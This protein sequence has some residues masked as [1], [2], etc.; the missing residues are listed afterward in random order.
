LILLCVVLTTLGCSSGGQLTD[1]GGTVAVDNEPVPSGTIHFQHKGDSKSAGAGATVTDGVFR[2]V[3]KAP[4]APGEYEVVLQAFRKTG[5]TFNDP[6]RGKVDETV[7]IS[8][9]D[10]PQIVQL[11]QDN[12]HS[13]KLNFSA[14]H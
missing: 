2:L 7:P 6:Q 3:S 5:K 12:E 13:L 14:Q 11:S 8:L 10:S 9:A 4:L 1:V